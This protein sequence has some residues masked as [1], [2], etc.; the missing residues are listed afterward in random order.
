MSLDAKQF[1]G[2]LAIIFLAIP[3]WARPAAARTDVAQW[4]NP[5]TTAIGNTQLKPGDY[6]L[7]AREAENQLEV[8]G[9]DGRVVAQVPCHWVQ[10][11]EKAQDTEIITDKDRIVQ[12]RFQG[13]TEAIQIQ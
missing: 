5:Q 12:V 9:P 6:H 2:S 7:K 11:S 3:V 8:L 10:L 1:L 13:R 4:D